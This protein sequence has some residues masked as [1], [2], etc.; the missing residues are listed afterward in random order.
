[1]RKG[2]LSLVLSLGCGVPG[3]TS[4]DI[5]GLSPSP[6]VWLSGLVRDEATGAPIAQAAIQVE[7]RSTRTGADG[8][9]RLEGLT[10]GP[11]SGS[12]SAEGFELH[13]FALELK[14]GANP[15]DLGLKRLSC[16]STG[17]STGQFCHAATGRCEA[18]AGAAELTGGVTDRCTGQPISARVSMGGKSTCSGDEKPYFRLTG[19]SAGGPQ[20]LAAGKRGYRPLLTEIFLEPGFNTFAISLEPEGG[21]GVTPATEPCVCNEVRCQ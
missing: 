2:F 21:C 8:A 12:A 16:F 6:R 19:L 20:A 3:L 1:M 14:P 17:C 4:E 18:A 13:P 9:Y 15:L 10:V 7:G 11:A 5:Y